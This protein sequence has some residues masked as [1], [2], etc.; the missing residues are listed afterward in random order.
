MSS[1]KTTG[2][3]I[4][5]FLPAPFEFCHTLPDRVSLMVFFCT[6]SWW[7]GRK[8]LRLVAQQ[9]WHAFSYPKSVQLQHRMTGGHGGACALTMLSECR[10]SIPTTQ[11]IPAALC[12]QRQTAP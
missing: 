1:S 4:S 5:N 9:Q 6:E 12:A 10:W 11:T 7:F 2:L 3:R 8:V